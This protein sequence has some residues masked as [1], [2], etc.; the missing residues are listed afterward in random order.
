M[1]RFLVVVPALALICARASFAAPTGATVTPVGRVPFPERAYVVDL[2]RVVSTAAVHPEIR[3]NGLVVTGA[4]L[5]P[6]SSGDVAT[7]VVLA[8]DTSQSMAGKPLAG[9]LGAAAKFIA[10]RDPSTLVGLVTFNGKVTVDRGLT[11]DGAELRRAL[12][13]TRSV[14]YGTRIFDAIGRSLRLL[15][16]RHVVAGSVIVLSDGADVGSTATLNSVLARASSDHIRIFAV[17]LHS[18]AFDPGPLR[19]AAAQTNGTYAE[20]TGAARL[21]SI[22]AALGSRLAREYLLRY[23]SAARPGTDV[24]ATFLF[25]ALGRVT[26]SYTAPTASGLAPYHASL[27]GRFF[28]SAESLVVLSLLAAGITG[29]VLYSVMSAPRRGIVERIEEIVGTTG[30][31][32]SPPEPSAE[33]PRPRV[34]RAGSVGGTWLRRLEEEF[35]IGE[36]S[37]RPESFV[38]AVGVATFLTFLVLAII[39]IPLALLAF[40]VPVF[41]RT[42]VTRKVKAV[43][44]AFADILPETLQLLASAL[45]SGHSLIG[46]MTVVVERAPQP[47]K[48]EF[49]QVLTDDQLGVP[50]EQSLQRI[51]RRMKS[52]D[53]EQVGLLGELQR[54]VGG[55][56]AEVL[57][58]VV[59]TVRERAEVRR[60]AQT[61]TAQ[62]RLARWIL[63]VLPVVLA[64]M[65]LAMEPKLM[66]PMLASGGG[67]LALV[68][69]SLF[70]VAGSLW[71]KK[72]VEIEV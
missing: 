29:F 63:T 57:D 1:A 49:G 18:K 60:L 45:R 56:A 10:A 40:L 53:M 59:E 67:Q 22:Y 70:V 62:G 39:S 4:T 20:A 12:Q 21:G 2:P 24:D 7:G 36:I 25:G 35:E 9:A 32:P 50:L 41:A 6:I 52:R 3:E 13:R 61:M 51:A 34:R 28:L 38:L 58:T 37:L 42:W 71:I 72:I 11:T 43:R 68:V 65:M 30:D 54:T 55:N 5:T 48:R 16:S 47:L 44:N 15:E 17:G 8:I 26:T 64:L 19:Q 27:A 69:A 46:A 33:R 66:K 14:A 23:T 31:A